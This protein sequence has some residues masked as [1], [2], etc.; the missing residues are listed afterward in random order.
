MI[1]YSETL[2]CLHGICFSVFLNEK[3]Y[4]SRVNNMDMSGNTTVF[5]IA[6]SFPLYE[7]IIVECYDI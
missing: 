1:N 3:T 7:A 4:G 5:L 2:A 6:K